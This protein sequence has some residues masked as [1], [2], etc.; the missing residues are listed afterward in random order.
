[1]EI[2]ISCSAGLHHDGGSSVS[3]VDEVI[4]EHPDV[5]LCDGTVR[6]TT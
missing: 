2:Q 1:M 3:V 5:L 6:T 4:S